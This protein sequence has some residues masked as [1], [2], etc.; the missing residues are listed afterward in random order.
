M[1][2]LDNF[3]SVDTKNVPCPKVAEREAGL[4]S[5]EEVVECVRSADV[6]KP[7]KAAADKLAALMSGTQ[8]NQKSVAIVLTY[9]LHR[10]TGT[11]YLRR[12]F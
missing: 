8:P 2:Q 12:R 3:D 11:Y 4:G 7:A 9:L 5:V 10:V 1:I 6:L